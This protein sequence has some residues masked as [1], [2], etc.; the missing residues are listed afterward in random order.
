[1]A[2]TLNKLPSEPKQ[3]HIKVFSYFSDPSAVVDRALGPHGE[4]KE[5]GGDSYDEVKRR[6][7]GEGGSGVRGSQGGRPTGVADRRHRTRLSQVVGCHPAM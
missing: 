3:I 2:L 1:M 4:Q 6:P 7:Q 5:V